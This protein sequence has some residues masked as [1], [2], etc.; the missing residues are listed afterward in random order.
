MHTQFIRTLIVVTAAAALSACG[1]GSSGGGTGVASTPPPPPGPTPPPPATG[2]VNIFPSVTTST[3]YP[4]LGYE[5]SGTNP[6]AASL[7]GT[8]FS[9][10]YDAGS[11]SYIMDVPASQPGFFKADTTGDRYWNGTLADGTG[12]AQPIVLDVFR[13]GSQNSDLA[14][15][16]TSFGIYEAN[17]GSEVGAFAFGIPTASSGVPVSGSATY[18]AFV[19]AKADVDYGIRGSATLDF[20]FGAGTLSGHF[21]PVIYDLLAGNTSLGHYGFVNT[22]YSAGSNVFSGNLSSPGVTGQGSF[23]GQFTGPAAQELMARFNAPFIDPRSK[24]QKE[25]FG[26]WVGKRP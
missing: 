24:Q 14:L 6:T 13:P 20:N 8:G 19:A 15:T 17:S 4:T 21:D 25:M 1:G 5:G 23:N 11:K 3:Q 2:P 10:R 7:T 26:V 9:V 12:G 16:Y 18:S 22:V